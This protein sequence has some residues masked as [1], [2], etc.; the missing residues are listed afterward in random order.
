MFDC[1]R[2]FHDSMITIIKKYDHNHK[3][4][5]NNSYNTAEMIV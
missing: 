1:F 2:I 5:N 3:K 4:K